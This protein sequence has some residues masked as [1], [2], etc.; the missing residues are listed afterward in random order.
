MNSQM[1]RL[2]LGAKCGR[3]SGG[4]QAPSLGTAAESSARAT[5]SRCNRLASTRPVKPMPRSARNARRGKRRQ[6]GSG[7]DRSVITR[8]ESE[9]RCR[10]LVVGFPS[11]FAFLT[12]DRF[13]HPIQFTRPVKDREHFDAVSDR[14]VEDEVLPE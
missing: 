3:P 6:L 9:Y 1:T 7:R 2:A 4:A 12:E 14:A 11:L 10:L 13:Q 5:P 8:S